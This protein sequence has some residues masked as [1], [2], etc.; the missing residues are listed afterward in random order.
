LDIVDS[1]PGVYSLKSAFMIVVKDEQI[2]A[3][4]YLDQNK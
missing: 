4:K 3:R 1:V 2:K